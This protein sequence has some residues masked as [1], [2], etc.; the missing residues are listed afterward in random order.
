VTRNVYWDLLREYAVEECASGGPDAHVAIIGT[1][2]REL[3]YVPEWTTVYMAGMYAN[4]YTCAGGA[5]QW[6]RV[7]VGPITPEWLAIA[8]VPKRKE[9]RPVLG[10]EK[11]AASHASWRTW[12][13]EEWPRLFESEATYD[14]YWDSIDKHVIY[15]GRYASMKVLEV[16]YRAGL[17][18]TVH[19]PDTR[20]RGGKFQRRTFAKLFPERAEWL[21]ETEKS[22]NPQVLAELQL[23]AETVMQEMRT[24]LPDISW[25]DVEVFLCTLR[26]AIGSGKYPGRTHDSELA[27][28]RRTVAQHG[29]DALSELPFMQLRKRLFESRFLAEL[30]AEPWTTEEL[31]DK[32]SARMDRA[33]RY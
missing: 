29:E 1:H 33:L 7:K 10:H 15:F 8:H 30:A 18:G 21:K 13:R 6:G 32:W 19:Q 5:L 31:E 4:A 22:D 2:L 23:M 24:Y 3:K 28:W 9:R 12:S 20:P 14:E 17:T 27:F 25:F 16:M 11:F 26:Q